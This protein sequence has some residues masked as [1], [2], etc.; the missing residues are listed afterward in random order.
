MG[1]NLR[2]AL[3]QAEYEAV[4]ADDPNAQPTQDVHLVGK[5]CESGDILINH[6]HLPAVQPGDVLAVKS[7]GAYG[8]SMASNYNRNPIPAVV[9][10]ENGQAKLVVR[11]QSYADLT[12]ND[13]SYD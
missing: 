2:P 1:D 7:C 6:A 5:Y 12:Q 3:Y 4:K 9:F 13:L 8:Y 11:R 10:A